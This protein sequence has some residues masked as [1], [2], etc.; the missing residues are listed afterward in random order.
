MHTNTMMMALQKFTL[1]LVKDI[2][3]QLKPVN[4]IL[5]KC[6]HICQTLQKYF[7]HIGLIITIV[8]YK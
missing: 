3:K 8:Q 6:S 1:M 2:S 7:G 4:K 5:H